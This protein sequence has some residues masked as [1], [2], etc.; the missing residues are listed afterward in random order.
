MESLLARVV[1]LAFGAAISPTHFALEVLVL[2]G[3]RHPV[4]R[5][6]AV[7]GGASAVLAV[8]ALLGL[9]LLDHL[10]TK[11]GHSPAGAAID[12][13]AAVLLALLAFRA[14]HRRPTAA[15]GHRQRTMSRIAEAPTLSF[16]GIG[17]VAMLLNFSTIV[18]FFPALHEISRSP[19]DRMEKAAAVLV[20]VVIT[21]L[22]VLIPV[23][24][25]AGLGSRADPVLARLNRFVGGHS[26]Q[27]TAGIEIFFCILLIWKGIGELRL[28]RRAAREWTL[29]D[30]WPGKRRGS[31]VSPSRP[32][33]A[34]HGPAVWL[35]EDP[36]LS[37]LTRHGRLS[38][39]IDYGCPGATPSR[40]CRQP[41]SIRVSEAHDRNRRPGCRR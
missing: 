4:S 38:A 34:W 12:L 33:P 26:R 10:D 31:A 17:G 23:L 40:A 20:L 13:G 1:P 8:Y 39:V 25:A 11:H 30:A 3:R 35:H 5:A 29:A 9:T 21:L 27:I 37:L 18:L 16:V 24:L 41:A 14:L 19:V 36:G 28:C 32:A 6:W 2:S 22:P 15:E 7:A